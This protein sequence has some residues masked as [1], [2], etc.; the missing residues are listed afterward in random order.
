M[1]RNDYWFRYALSRRRMLR[2]SALGVAGLVGT[3]LI[4]CG[5]D[6]AGNEAAATPAGSTA[7]APTTFSG[8]TL[9]LADIPQ[10]QDF[11]RHTGSMPSPSIVCDC[12][13]GI[14]GTGATQNMLVEKIE[15]PDASNYTLKFRQGIKFHNGREMTSEDVKL[16]LQRIKSTPGTWMKGTAD[17]IQSMETPD[18]QSITLRLSAP[19]SP[20]IALLSELW[21]MAPESPGW[22]GTISKPI[23]T[24]PFVWKD[25][26]PNDKII[27]ER[28]PDYWQKDKPRIDGIE[29]K[30]IADG[31]V[32]ALLAGDLHI[33]SVGASDMKLAQSNSSIELKQQKATS[34]D[35]FSFQNK[36]PNKPYDD[37]RVRQALAYALDKEALN[38]FVT[39]GT[40]K[41]ANQMA[42]PGSFYWDEKLVDPYAK[43]DLTK[44]QQLLSAA[45]VSNLTPVM[46][47]N[48]NPANAEVVAAQLAKI[49]VKP[50]LEVADDI[51]TEKRISGTTDWDVYYAGSGARADIALRFV[52][53]MSDGPNPGL[54]GSPQDP[55]YDRLVKEAW[56]EVD[57]AKRKAK[58][59]EAW[60]VV[61]EKLYTIPTYHNAGFRGVRKEVLGFETGAV[62]N[63]NRIDGGVA[64]VTF[65]K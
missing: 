55:Q 46:P 49:G 20:L 15:A 1:A 28:F 54:W 2:A 19:Y 29:I 13:T 14:D 45:G 65:K 17:Y 18:K 6:D 64:F 16:N 62:E 11:H 40:G 9:R 59:L 23:G 25:W 26:I 39:G 42:A 50:K 44:A 5:S 35:F 47:V 24:G 43:P 36:K 58:Y 37:I 52:R 61:M 12:P 10:T 27:L 48:T 21:L 41:V 7:G 51:T 38:Q 60:K 31:K 30:N 32:T 53:L 4:G 22:D 33:T 57:A 56:A 63:S 8:G 3:T 34:W